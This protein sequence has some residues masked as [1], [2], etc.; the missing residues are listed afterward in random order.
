MSLQIE[1]I[2][3]RIVRLPAFAINHVRKSTSGVCLT[4]AFRVAGLVPILPISS[5][6]T[7]KSLEPVRLRERTISLICWAS[8][9]GF[10][11]LIIHT[12]G[13]KLTKPPPFAC[14]VTC[15]MLCSRSEYTLEL[16]CGTTMHPALQK[17]ANLPADWLIV[18]SIRWG[19]CMAVSVKSVI[20]PNIKGTDNKEGMSKL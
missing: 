13:W 2:F 17:T 18:S 16:A 12:L 6:T 7:S 5:H 4:C 14:S 20:V 19:E 3:L 10:V 9:S 15:T 1:C 11:S 8:V